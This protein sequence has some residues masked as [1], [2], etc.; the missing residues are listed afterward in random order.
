MTSAT[1]ETATRD[2]VIRRRPE[3]TRLRRGAESFD[4][5]RD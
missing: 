3:L 2:Q 1:N 5:E 4:D